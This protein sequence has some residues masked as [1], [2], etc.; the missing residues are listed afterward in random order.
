MNA[1][2]FAIIE[3][4]VRGVVELFFLAAIPF[5]APMAFLATDTFLPATLLARAER[6]VAAFFATAALFALT[7]LARAE[8]TVAAF[9]ATPARF[10][11]TDALRAE[12]TRD[13]T[14]AEEA[15]AELFTGAAWAE[16]RSKIAV[17]NASA[18]MR[19][20]TM[21]PRRTRVR[22]FFF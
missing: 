5:L 9:F 12:L 21:R 1:A 18:P 17:G 19:V 20:V 7:L 15:F 16:L 6:T 4:R 13:F 11:A 3:R 8:R 14:S 2:F 10:A 22:L